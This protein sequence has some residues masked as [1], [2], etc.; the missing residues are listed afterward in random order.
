MYSEQDLVYFKP[1]F[2]SAELYLSRFK[3]KE[4]FELE[5]QI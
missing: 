4:L 3:A 1:L 5:M 2:F